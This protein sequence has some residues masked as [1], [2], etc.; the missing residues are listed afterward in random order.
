MKTTSF[1]A[2]LMVLL[3]SCTGV[4]NVVFNFNGGSFQGWQDLTGVDPNQTKGPLHWAISGGENVTAVAGNTPDGGP[5]ISQYVLPGATYPT[6]LPHPA[7][8][9]RSPEFT[10]TGE[11]D[12]TAYLAG[13]HGYGADVTGKLVANFPAY[14]FDRP[15]DPIFPSFLGIA[16]RNVNTGVYDAVAK[17]SDPYDTWQ[18][19]TIPQAQLAVL[20]QNA[21][22]T[23]DLIDV[24]EY[25]WGWIAMDFVTLP[26]A[27]IRSSD[28]TPADGA[29]LVNSGAASWTAP[30]GYLGQYNVY[31]TQDSDPNVLDDSGVGTVVEPTINLGSLEALGYLETWY[32]RVDTVDPNEGGTPVV[33]KGTVW[34]FTTI[35]AAPIITQH[36]AKMQ[37]AEIGDTVAITVA[38]FSPTAEALSY[39]WYRGQSPDDSAP[40][41]GADESTFALQLT[42]QSDF[43]TY[44]CRATTDSGTVDSTSIL[45]REKKLLAHWPLNNP[46]DPNSTVNGTPHLVRLGT[47]VLVEGPV[48][49]LN[50]MYFNGSAGFYTALDETGNYFDDLYDA[51][52]VSVWM[53]SNKI[54]LW[55]PFVSKNGDDSQGWQFRVF[56][57]DSNG[58]ICFTTRGTT[59]NEDGPTTTMGLF[60]NKWHHIVATY[61]GVTRRIYVDGYFNI[62]LAA[63][64]KIT[65]TAS[66]VGIA[67]RY[68]SPTNIG[69]FLTAA[70]YDMRLYNYPLSDQ[71]IVDMTAAVRPICVTPIA[72]DLTGDCRVD[73]KDFSLMAAEWLECMIYPDCLTSP[74]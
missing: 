29:V 36:P 73:L 22:Y 27:L 32:W 72:T 8:L 51:M 38:A 71:E 42:A 31:L 61:D 35:G 4:C 49:G 16:L 18:M 58:R 41:A 28:P 13:G 54:D 50:A 59:G 21:V 66:P 20:D 45:L 11:G 34:S 30:T 2:V 5:F 3:M 55:R 7:M 1:M 33:T 23:L 15:S 65:S 25:D 62:Q 6:D 43:G 70:M 57:L 60:D 17:R 44:Y 63:T 48:D 37:F 52:T 39:Q 19:V 10:L 67:M 69:S 68:Q 40:V 53:K 12:L 26:G 47:P 56:G 74:W 9:L 64:G 24:R 46:D 14:S